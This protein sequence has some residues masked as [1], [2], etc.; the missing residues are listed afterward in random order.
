M[1]YSLQK[2]HKFIWC[3]RALLAYFTHFSFF[4]RE[5]MVVD[6]LCHQPVRRNIETPDKS[7]YEEWIYND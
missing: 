1:T 5:L 3:T 7:C 2:K 4:K 6:G